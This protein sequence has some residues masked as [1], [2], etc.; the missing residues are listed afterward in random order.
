MSPAPAPNPGTSSREDVRK[1]LGRLG[2]LRTRIR[3]ILATQGLA[4]WVVFALGVLAV[5]FLADWLLDLPIGVRRFVR[6]GL[7]QA[8]EGMP[9]LVLIP[10][11]LVSGFLAIALTR[12][13]HGAAPL[14]CF[15]TAGC[16][17]LFVWGAVRAFAPLRTPLSDDD[18][19]LSVEN[20]YRDLQDRLA[21]AL[22]FDEELANPSRGE[23]PAM[24]QAVVHEAAE[25][26]RS[27]SFSNA[28]SG[29]RALRWVGGALA[30]VVVALGANAVLAEEIGLWARRS[31][32]LEDVAWPKATSMIA[33][34]L[35]PEGDFVDHDPA[36]AYEVPIGRS[37]TVYARA[38]GETPKGAQVLDLVPGQQP[39]ARRMFEVPGQPGVFA[40]EFL[41]VR[42]PFDFLL[43]GGDDED[44]TPRYR[45]E[46][47]IPPRVLSMRSTVTYP[48]YLR[49]DPEQ[50]P[51]GSVTVPQ[52]AGVEVEFTTDLDVATARA[53]LGDTS[54]VASRV[55]D[56]GR[57]WRF[58]YVAER[59]VAGRL[60]L[61]TPDG[62]ENDPSS[63][64]FDV[65]VKTDQPPRIDWIWP[66]GSVE[67]TPDGRVPVLA[68][69]TDDHG[70]AEIVLEV[71]VNA[72]DPLRIPLSP[73]VRG[74]ADDAPVP[75]G[76]LDGDYGR[77]RVLMY[78]PLEIG[79]LRTEDAEG[80]PAPLQPLD[81]VSMRLTAEDYRGQV[82][83]SEWVR[84]D[85]SSPTSLERDLYTQRSNVRL[86]LE[87]VRREQAT[88]LEDVKTLMSSAI[89]DAEL[90]LLKTVR[91]SQGKIAQDA[92]RAVQ[93]LLAVFNAFVYDRLGAESPN[94]KI[95]GFLD[96]H[97]RAT[98]GLEAERSSEPAVR[99]VALRADWAGDPVFPYALYDEIVA[100]WKSKSIFDKGL[101]DKMLTAIEH[102]VEVGARRA[103]RAHAAAAAAVG[104]DRAKI[105]ALLEAQQANLEALDA[106]MVAMKGWQD[107]QELKLKLRGIIEEQEVLIR[108]Q[109]ESA[110]DDENKNSGNSR[111]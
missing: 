19:A 89:G 82:R 79:R 72:R 26:V 47:T 11:L 91:F 66:R 52:G 10:A 22:D 2:R 27:L 38:V 34:D 87:Q 90:D 12:R 93:E 61:R 104:G 29:R 23:S 68:Q 35:Q 8:P 101:L 78:L 74:S 55:G 100:A 98:Y 102:A 73:W 56:D 14:F 21:S 76:A 18:L 57:R 88:R 97:H 7:L 63:D 106:L 32:L 37:L 36:D 59:T 24:M 42:R 103:P 107:L 41:D 62:K 81:S 105:Q 20:R 86:S 1:I 48:D 69:C 53:V 33:V 94:A 44:D 13:G 60:V 39:L 96:R 64:S 54:I 45:V 49:R 109:D 31:L 83:E 71:R 85:L 75:S 110:K 4:R 25:E 17:G 84:A 80:A 58:Q 65:R 40:Y 16:A 3:G 15:I 95:L 43:R 5:Y 51:D 9:I 77:E 46:I 50:I 92:D 28:V 6:L 111:R 30:A 67:V 70:V 99:P 108:R